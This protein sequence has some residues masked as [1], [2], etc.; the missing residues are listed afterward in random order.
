MVT[1]DHHHTLDNVMFFTF[2]LQLYVSS[3]FTR[4]MKFGNDEK[5]KYSQGFLRVDMATLALKPVLVPPCD[6]A[7]QLL[8]RPYIASGLCLYR[9]HLS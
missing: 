2:R 4:E 6:R 7:T 8:S 1:Q 5:L 3:S 9:R